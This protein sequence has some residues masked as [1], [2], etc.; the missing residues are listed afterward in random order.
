MEVIARIRKVT[1]DCHYERLKT[2]MNKR[3]G[4]EN[5]VTY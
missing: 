4:C 1:L 3:A 2:F 5:I